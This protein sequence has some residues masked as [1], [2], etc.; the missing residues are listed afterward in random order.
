MCD[1][2]RGSGDKPPD[3]G[4]R[5]GADDGLLPGRG[6]SDALGR[7]GNLGIAT[8]LHILCA[9]QL[10]EMA[11]ERS[12]DDINLAATW[13]IDNGTQGDES[14]KLNACEQ[15][16]T[17]RFLMH[18]ALLELN[19]LSD[20]AIRASQIAEEKRELQLTGGVAAD[21]GNEE[22]VRLCAG[23][24]LGRH[25]TPPVALHHSLLP[26]PHPQPSTAL[27]CFRPWL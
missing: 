24:L 15:D 23:C 10:C 4:G 7:Q 25:A 21:G 14:A 3:N 1:R 18:Y 5:I 17:R 13:L 27:V 11:L 8:Y 6:E 16:P 26:S 22:E 19:R 20:E 9:F 2:V 12:N